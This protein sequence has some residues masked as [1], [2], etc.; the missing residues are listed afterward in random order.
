MQSL[1]N[2]CFIQFA[3]V[4][5]A[6]SE[7][8]GHAIAYDA[9]FRHARCAIGIA[10]R[11]EATGR[12]LGVEAGVLFVSYLFQT[13]PFNKLFLEVPAFNLPQVRSLTDHLVRE[14]TIPQHQYFAHEY[15]DLHIFSIKREAW[16]LRPQQGYQ[17]IKQATSSSFLRRPVEHAQ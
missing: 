4:G 6:S 17:S 3:V 12:G 1:R 10:L 5:Q 7:V 15:H 16:P 2:D 9:D 13:W 11:G 8:I 14:A